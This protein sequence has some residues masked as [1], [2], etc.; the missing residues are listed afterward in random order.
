MLVI[1]LNQHYIEF[2]QVNWSTPTKQINMIHQ[3]YGVVVQKEYNKHQCW[4]KTSIPLRILNSSTLIK[5][6]TK[7][8]SRE[9]ANV[10]LMGDIPTFLVGVKIFMSSDISALIKTFQLF[11]PHLVTC[12]YPVKKKQ[13]LKTQLGGFFFLY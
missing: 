8:I 5:W 7:S 11:A 12:P 6:L 1:W 4:K 2:S 13:I 3:T 10:D 9:N